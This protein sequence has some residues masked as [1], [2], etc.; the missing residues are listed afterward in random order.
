MIYTAPESTN[1]SVLI[2][3]LEHVQGASHQAAGLM[4]VTYLFH[5]QRIFTCLSTFWPQTEAFIRTWLP[6][7][8]ISNL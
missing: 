6:V 3:A 2:T 5:N 1:I 8:D 4:L 7:A